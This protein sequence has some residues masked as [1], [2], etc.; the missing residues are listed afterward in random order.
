MW[1]TSNRVKRPNKCCQQILTCIPYYEKKNHTFICIL[2][3]CV[4][5]CNN[6]VGEQVCQKINITRGCVSRSYKA[7]PRR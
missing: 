4:S 7:D 3:V 6:I 1:E 5:Q 2:I